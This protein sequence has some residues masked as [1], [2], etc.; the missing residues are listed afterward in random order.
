[1]KKMYESEDG[2]ANSDRQ[3]GRIIEDVYARKRALIVF[4]GR[5]G[6]RNEAEADTGFR[7]NG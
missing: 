7:W 2:E 4:S 3:L 5:M 1:M 6:C